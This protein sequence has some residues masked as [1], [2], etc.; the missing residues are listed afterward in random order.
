[1]PGALQLQNDRRM[2]DIGEDLVGAYL[3]RIERCSIVQFNVRTGVDQAEIDVVG[4]NLEAT[5][6]SRVWLC[7]VSTHTGGLGGYGGDAT[8]K[9]SRKIASVRKYADA[10][11]PGVARVIEVWS[12]KIT[13]AMSKKLEPVLANEPDVEVIANSLYSARVKTLAYQARKETAFSDSPAF[14]LLQIL[15]RLPDRP[16]DLS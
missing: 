6:V 16:L 3:S 15:T 11:F 7:E 13:P 10:T 12:P 2:I 4:L 14:R 1:M 8:G 5:Q 9:I